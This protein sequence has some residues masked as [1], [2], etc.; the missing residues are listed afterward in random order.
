MTDGKWHH[1][2]VTWSTRDGVWEV[3]QDGVKKGSGQNLAPW[4]AIK[5]GGIFILGQEQVGAT[6]SSLLFA[7]FKAAVPNPRTA[8]R[9]R[10]G[11]HLVPVPTH[12][13]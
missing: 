12:K 8:D 13:E 11:G 7:S 6:G 4:H 1:V 2:C 3:Y 5:A 10:S 9:Y